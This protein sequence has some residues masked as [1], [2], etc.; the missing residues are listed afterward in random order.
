[1]A[2]DDESVVQKQTKRIKMEQVKFEGNVI[3]VIKKRKK[4][5]GN[6]GHVDIATLQRLYICHQGNLANVNLDGKTGGDRKGDG[7]P[8]DNTFKELW[9][10]SRRRKSRG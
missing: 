10:T 8:E 6:C 9:C 3:G 5:K 7:V 1:M 4:K 2:G